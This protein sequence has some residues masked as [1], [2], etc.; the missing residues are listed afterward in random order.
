MM[1]NSLRLGITSYYLKR[2]GD[3]FPHLVNDYEITEAM[4]VPSMLV[5]L[6]EQ[7]SEDIDAKADLQGLKLVLCAGAPLAESLRMRFLSIFYDT[8]KLIQAYGTSECG[9][10]STF[11]Y[12]DPDVD[13]AKSVGR[14]TDAIQIR[15]SDE[16][17]TTSPDG[18]KAAELWVKGPQVMSGYRNDPDLTASTLTDDG[19][20]KTGDVG[21]ID[22]TGKVFLVDRAKDIIKVDGHTVAPFEIESVLSESPEVKDV[23]ALAS[24]KSEDEHP[25]V[26]IEDS[27]S[28]FDKAQGRKMRDQIRGGDSEE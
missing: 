21:Y 11:G 17:V 1:I 10:L 18:K 25:I 24:Q 15:V 3:A 20:L 26:F 23:A 12:E 27:F 7:A 22:D 16:H 14:L 5:T 28:K 2:F 8:P 6:V 9:W 19:W 13:D 4:V